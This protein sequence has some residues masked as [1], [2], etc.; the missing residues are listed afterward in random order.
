MKVLPLIIVAA[1]S[2]ATVS[3]VASPARADYEPP[4][5]IGSP[6]GSGGG[7]GTR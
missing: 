2:V 3:T 5:G 6:G 7:T 4:S 1:L